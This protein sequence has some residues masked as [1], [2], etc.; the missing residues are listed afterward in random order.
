M[1]RA[2]K[3]NIPR[4]KTIVKQKSNTVLSK[5]SANNAGL[6]FYQQS[7]HKWELT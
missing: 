3:D 5:S 4:Y 6:W 7:A 1:S 2:N